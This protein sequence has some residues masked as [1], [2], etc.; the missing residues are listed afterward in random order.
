VQSVLSFGVEVSPESSSSSSSSSSSIG[1]GSSS[2][3]IEPG[4]YGLSKVT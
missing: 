4:K 2:S 1:G 3:R